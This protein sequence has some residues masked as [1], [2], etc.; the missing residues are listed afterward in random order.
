MGIDRAAPTPLYQQLAAR[1]RDQI[2]AGQLSG[3]IPSIVR[4]AEEYDL[5]EVT[6]R[7]ALNVLRDEGLLEFVPGR[8]TFVRG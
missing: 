3:Q 4:L 8:G 7:S 5:A 1:L 2:A 6:V